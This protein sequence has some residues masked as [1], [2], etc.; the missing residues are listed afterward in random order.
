[1]KLMNKR[2]TPWRQ[3]QREEA[4]R[5]RQKP[6]HEKWYRKHWYVIAGLAGVLGWV[7]KDGADA[8]DKAS[9]LPTKLKAVKSQVLSWHYNDG[10][11][12]GWWTTS[13]EGLVD[14][15]DVK[16]SQ[17]RARLSLSAVQ[18]KVHGEFSSETVCTIA[19][20]IGVL[21]LDG[22]IHGNVL[23]GIAY[24]IVGGKREN[25]ATFSVTPT[26]DGLTVLPM[27]DPL[28]LFGNRLDLISAFAEE[29]KNHSNTDCAVERQKFISENIRKLTGHADKDGRRRVDNV[30]RR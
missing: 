16:V 20:L 18:G 12:N 2:P 15:G 21:M 7:L 14:S 4:E 23:H 17:I 19:P 1:M 9:T 11:W 28:G 3:R 5:N 25:F 27:Q 26:K 13:T 30:F 6:Q 29:Q 8:L 22:D 10:S 24:Q